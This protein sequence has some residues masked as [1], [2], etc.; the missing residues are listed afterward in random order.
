MKKGLI[1][2]GAA[3]LVLSSCSQE[4]VLSVNN[5][6]NND[7]HI[8]FR[9]RSNKSTRSLEYS[10]YNLDDFMVFGFKGWPDDEEKV[11]DYF[12]N[13]DP[14]KFTR[15]DGGLLFDSETPY[16][17]PADGS[18]LYFAAYAPSTLP[19]TK[20]GEY[21]G[22][23]CDFTV[24]S[25]ITKQIDIISASGGS[26]L[27]KNEDD[28]E[29]TF[30]H[31]LTKV[32]ISEVH[33]NDTR[34]KYEIM[35]VKF[36]NIHNS[37]KYEF[38]GEK[39]VFPDESNNG[40][41]REDGFLQD[42][43]GYGI[44]WQPTG[45]QTGDME[46]IFSTPVVLD[47]DNT[48]VDVMKGSD[49]DSDTKSESFMLIPQ[50]L[51]NAFLNEEGNIG[52]LEFDKE[53]S[54]IAFLVRITNTITNEVIYPYA[55]D[56]DGVSTVDAISKTIGEG[57]DAVTY[58]WAAFPISSLWAP[59]TYVDYLVEFTDGAGFVAPGADPEVELQPILGRKIRFY[60]AVDNWGENEDGSE[61]GQGQ[62]ITVGQN[63]ELGVDVGNSDDAF[64]DD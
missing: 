35:G 18:W 56:E 64:G 20:F 55:K 26:N 24:D 30:Q 13:G 27:E 32:Y 19:M 53:M 1:L 7:N 17:Y 50:Q 31:A 52:G 29:I 40:T 14:V 22:I 51:S 62:W 33:N 4:D 16:Y 45:E 49:T 63:S 57:E 41:I 61:T 42:A 60:V 5:T 39:A 8:T 38:R 34:Y 37:G 9:V 11:I 6:T 54:Y 25:D 2:M 36:G 23:T 3:A 28:Q 10:T 21:G 15:E 48:S 43:V 47:G 44:F 12:A 58:A 46:Y 59:G